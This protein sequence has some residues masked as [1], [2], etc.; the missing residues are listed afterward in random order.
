[1]DV[2]AAA[3]LLA[4]AREAAENAYAPYSAFPVG[5][6]ILTAQG[7]V[8]T[9]ANVENVS[10]GLTICAERCAVFKAVSEGETRFQ[11]VAVWASR[12]PQGA[13]TPCGACRQVLAEFMAPDAWMILSDE[14]TGLPRMLT[15]TALLPEAFAPGRGENCPGTDNN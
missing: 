1:M 2:N 7:Q 14:T 12:R 3:A 8:I 9:G 6:A 5:A 15:L 4:A 13:V 11:A 10:Y